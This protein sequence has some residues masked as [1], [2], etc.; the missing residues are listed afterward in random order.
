MGKLGNE[1]VML[2]SFE[3]ATNLTF[4]GT[5]IRVTDVGKP[6]TPCGEPKTDIYVR[7][8]DEHGHVTELKISCKQQD[9]D[10][11][12]SKLKPAAAPGILSEGW[13]DVVSS[14]AESLSPVILSRPLFMPNG[15][16]RV[17]PMSY[18]TGWRVDIMRGQYHSN[19]SVKLDDVDDSLVWNMV[20]GDERDVDKANAYVN[21]SLVESSGIANMVYV[22][23]PYA[24]AQQILDACV[25]FDEFTP[26]VI[27]GKPVIA[28]KAVNYRE[29]KGKSDGR[30][31]LAVYVSWGF[32]EAGRVTAT[33][34]FDAPLAYDSSE[35]DV[36]IRR[37]IGAVHEAHAATGD[38]SSAFADKSIV[39][40]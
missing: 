31:S 15:A 10:F 40:L 29:C 35:I 33:P 12:V 11:I 1:D 18:T 21:G 27:G 26:D 20:F 2:A 30:R 39:M 3:N 17:V 24:S 38:W 37:V 22:G 9:Y 7:G 8:V 14:A 6:M 28:L 32:D 4:H 19:M 23:S 25:S 5:N 34:M 16:G 13:R 36:D